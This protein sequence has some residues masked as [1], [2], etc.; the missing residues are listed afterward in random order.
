M[1]EPQIALIHGREVAYRVL[2]GV[3]VPILFVHG[4][5]ASMSS[6]A[7]IPERLQAAGHAVVLVDLQGHGHS[8]LE[9]GDYSLGA[10]ANTLRD[11]LDLLGMERVHLVGHSL[12][13]GVAMQFIYQFPD[14]ADH[15]VLVSSGGLGSSLNA[16]LRLATLPGSGLFVSAAFNRGTMAVVNWVGR[17]LTRA[18]V[19]DHALTPETL[20]TV[21][22]LAHPKRRAAFLSTLRGAISHRGQ[23]DSVM[24]KPHILGERPILIVW[25]DRDPLIPVEHGE[26]A[27]ELLPNSRLVVFIG[28]GHEPHLFDPARFT[29]EVLAH[30]DAKQPA[31]P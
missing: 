7:D 28:A 10:H 24:D 5:G 13:G 31:L 30:L 19:N 16:G 18:G 23:I 3:G 1:V 27:H 12:G 26:Q 4:I 29:D 6:W 15:L 8:S 11:L 9:R 17:T 22:K 20:E 21:G 25:G 14:R 2:P